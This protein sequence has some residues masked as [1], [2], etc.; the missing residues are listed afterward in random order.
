MAEL[1]EL[2]H[3]N[4]SVNDEPV[5]EDVAALRRALRG[6]PRAQ[7][8]TVLRGRFESARLCLVEATGS[9]LFAVRAELRRTPRLLVDGWHDALVVLVPGLPRNADIASHASICRTVSRIHRVAPSALVGVSSPV[10]RLAHAARALD[11]AS[12]ALRECPQGCAVYADDVWFAVAISRLRD[13]LADSLA[14]GGPLARLDE[15]GKGGAELRATLTT[16][17]RHDGDV[18]G[19]AQQLHLHPNSLRYRLRRAA[20]VTGIDFADP[21]QRLVTLLALT[22]D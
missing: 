17:L 8:E 10:D 12:R 11:E 18:R 20:E 14:V 6:T 9:E 15:L 4:L 16:W 21:L 3:A 13:S 7:D 2:L 19:A 22:G 5:G 1:V